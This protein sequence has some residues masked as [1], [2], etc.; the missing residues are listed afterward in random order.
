VRVEVKLFAGLAQRAGTRT[1]SLELPAGATLAVAEAA[2]REKFAGGAWPKSA[3]LAVNAT[4]ATAETVLQ[5]GDTLAVIPPVSG[6]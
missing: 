4:Y 5:D 3:M 6:G 1:L 2:L